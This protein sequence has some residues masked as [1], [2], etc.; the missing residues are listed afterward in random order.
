MSKDYLARLS[1]SVEAGSFL[2]C[3]QGSLRY[4]EAVNESVDGA[5]VEIRARVKEHA[6]L[7]SQSLVNPPDIT[8]RK[9]FNRFRQPSP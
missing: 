7:K 1:I 2:T 6:R 4:Q 9:L 5:L 8:L 3:P